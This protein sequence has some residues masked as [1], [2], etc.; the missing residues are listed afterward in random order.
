MSATSTLASAVNGVLCQNHILPHFADT[1]ISRVSA[2]LPWVMTMA[3]S[4]SQ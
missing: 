3:N 2:I 1:K 4:I